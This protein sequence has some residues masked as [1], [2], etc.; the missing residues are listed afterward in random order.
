[1]TNEFVFPKLSV[2][3]CRAAIDIP[4]FS[5]RDF[6]NKEELGM[7][8]FGSVYRGQYNSNNDDVVVKVLRGHNRESKRLFLKEARL[9]S[10]LKGHKNISSFIAFCTEPYAIMLEYL[11][12]DFTVFEVNKK[13]TS[14]GEFLHFIDEQLDVHALRKCQTKIARDIADGLCYLHSNGVVHRDL[15]PE[16]ILVSNQHYTSELEESARNEKFS[17]N[18]ILCKL[19]DFGESRATNLQTQTLVQ[20]QTNRL[21]RGTPVYMAFELHSHPTKALTHDDLK[22]ADMWAFGLVMYCLLN[23]DVDHPYQPVFAE[24]GL[25]ESLDSLK[26]LHEARKVPQQRSNYE[27]LLLSEWWQVEEAYNACVKFDPNLRAQALEL[28]SIL[29]VKQPEESLNVVHLNVS[30]ATALSNFDGMLAENIVQSAPNTTAALRTADEIICSVPSNDG[31]NAC[32]FLDLAICDRFLPLD[33]CMTWDELKSIAENV[34]TE[35]PL[36]INTY[37]DINEIYEP[38]SAYTLLKKIAYYIFNTPHFQHSAFSTLRIFNTPHFQHSAFSTL[39]TPHSGTPHIHVNPN[40]GVGDEKEI[41][42]K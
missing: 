2:R 14:L 24:A 19:S 8:S 21:N 22:K 9:L 10:K 31:T 23:P 32:V 18:P 12:F 16:N 5:W 36:L 35:F 1:M 38:I 3:E 7:G 11:C 39:R 34:I 6:T 25:N 33:Q 28:S 4:S 42:S 29:S 40:G 15:K 13:V 41:Y 30:Q 17:S 26:C 27:F 20:S 37:R